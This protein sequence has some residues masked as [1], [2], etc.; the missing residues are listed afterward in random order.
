MYINIVPYS[1]CLE[2]N[3]KLPSPSRFENIGT[4]NRFKLVLF[5][6]LLFSCSA[7]AQ[8]GLFV[9]PKV[10]TRKGLL[11]ALNGNLT[12]P[13]A[14]FAKRFG[15]GYSFGPSVL[16]KTKKNWLFGAK[17]DFIFGSR[18][19]EDSFLINLQQ[20]NGGIIG[21]NG[22][23]S[24]L[25]VF[26]RG[27][28]IGLQAGKI[29]SFSPKQPD[30]GLMVLSAVGFIQHKILINDPNGNIAQIQDQYRRGYDRLANGWFVEQYAGYTYFGKNGLINFHIGLNLLVGF[31]QGRRDYLLDVRR[32]G[33]EKRT[34][35][36]WGLRGGW[37]IP[38]FKRKSEEFFFE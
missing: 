8:D 33:T 31:T 9:T 7:H 5:F 18:I 34:D 25:R 11:I 13:A 17:A 38:V 35:I 22:I 4:M 26:E 32:P 12:I 19:K 24:S 21:Q 27:Y 3:Y 23:R 14:D 30:N 36:I 29:F 6:T 20:S 1:P 10:E 2:I 28:S 37:Y 16:Y 15:V